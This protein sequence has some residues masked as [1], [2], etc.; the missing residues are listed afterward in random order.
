MRGQEGVRETFVFLRDLRLRLAAGKWASE[1]GVT[2]LQASLVLR[3]GVQGVI[4]EET[5]LELGS[6]EAANSTSERRPRPIAGPLRM[7]PPL[8]P[9]PRTKRQ[10]PCLAVDR[11]R[12]ARSWPGHV[13]S[14]ASGA[15]KT[16]P[17]DVL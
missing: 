1:R 9:K 3:L 11:H 2:A 12:W 6:P 16:R 5:G 4:S 10:G 14:Q 17:T 15:R 8:T 13:V 7:Q